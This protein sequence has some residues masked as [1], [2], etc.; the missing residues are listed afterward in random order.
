MATNPFHFS[1]SRIRCNNFPLY[2]TKRI[3]YSRSLTPLSRLFVVVFYNT[4]S[5]FFSC[6]HSYFPQNVCEGEKTTISV[7]FLFHT[8]HAESVPNALLVLSSVKHSL[9]D[10]HHS[11]PVSL[12]PLPSPFGIIS[13]AFFA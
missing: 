7:Y 10:D 9:S 13:T 2:N 5:F 11:L 8:A 1:L 12:V 6:G 4:V 3:N